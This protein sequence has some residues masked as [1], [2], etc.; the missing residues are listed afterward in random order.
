MLDVS[1]L[2]WFCHMLCLTKGSVLMPGT[3]GNYVLQNQEENQNHEYVKC[4][5]LK[6]YLS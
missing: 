3:T 6:L 1:T 4:E 5:C 2:V